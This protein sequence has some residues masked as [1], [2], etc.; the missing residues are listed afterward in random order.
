MQGNNCKLPPIQEA[1]GKADKK[2]LKKKKGK[3]C[4]KIPFSQQINYPL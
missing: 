4:E 2:K 1:L 3:S